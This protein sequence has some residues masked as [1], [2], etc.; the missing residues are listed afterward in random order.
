[1]TLD[2]GTRHLNCKFEVFDCKFSCKLE[3]VL[4][5]YCSQSCSPSDHTEVPISERSVVRR[6]VTQRLRASG[7]VPR[8][9]SVDKPH[10]L[11]SMRGAGIMVAGQEESLRP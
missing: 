6:P 5:T 3:C 9:P 11:E 1:M 7:N 8:E 2:L 4:V 10:A